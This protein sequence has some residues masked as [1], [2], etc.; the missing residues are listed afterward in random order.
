MSAQ[1]KRRVRL[2]LWIL[3]LVAAS[4]AA[5][6]I[7]VPYTIKATAL[8]LPAAEYSVSRTAGGDLVGSFRDN[9]DNLTRS[10]DVTPFQGGDVVRLTLAEGIFDGAP[11]R[12]GDPIAFITSNEDDRRLVELHGQLSVLRAELAYYTTGAKP[13]EVA[14][15]REEWML[16]RQQLAAQARLTERSRQLAAQS[17]L[18]QQDLDI[19]VDRL[20]LQEIAVRIAH[21]RY[22][23]TT[24][25]E[26]PEQ[27]ELIRAQ[28][29]ATDEQIQQLT[30]RLQH[31]SV[32]SPLDGSVLLSRDPLDELTILRIVETSRS[33]ALVP[34]S[35]SESRYVAPGQTVRYGGLRGA[36]T[37]VGNAVTVLSGRQAVYL[38]SVWTADPTI[39]AGTIANVVFRCKPVTLFEYAVRVVSR[40]N[41]R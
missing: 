35:W 23:S 22:L 12:T 4:Y 33:V 14:R 13:P 17:L 5:V 18:S 19:E 10:Y 31:L 9:V 30:R 38:T 6:V 29:R 7:Q 11:V 39:P 40:G 3:A 28:I 41:R 27:A 15:A 34:L 25:G 24:S 8:F 32:R 2:L 37:S 36:V 1:A 20:N 21:Q 26:K 16:A